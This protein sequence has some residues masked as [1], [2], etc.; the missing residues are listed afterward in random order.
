MFFVTIS[1]F[2]LLCLPAFLLPSAAARWC[3]Q[4][5]ARCNDRLLDLICGLKFEIRGAEHLPD[6]GALIASKHQSAWETI[7]YLHILSAP[8]MVL[9]KEL[10][11]LPFFGWYA[12][13]ANHLWV[14]RKGGAAALRSLLTRAKVALEEGRQILIFPE[15]TRKAPG[16]APDYHRGI[17]ALY[18]ELK[19]PC[20]P[21]ALNSGLFWRRRDWR[22]R[23]GTIIVEFGAPI[24]PG[25][26]GKA[27]MSELENRIETAT[28]K[29][30][31]GK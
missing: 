15:G 31:A 16:A 7:S 21:V 5:W 10:L 9:K 30:V 17:V 25:L 6:G 14:N 26:T 27:F 13:K 11:Y 2:I 24:P 22:R 28:N 18:R 23:P 12:L 4:S 29:L 3:I 20:V 8:A 19:V 1:G